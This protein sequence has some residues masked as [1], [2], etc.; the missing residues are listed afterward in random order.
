MKSAGAEV[1]H[2]DVTN[3]DK[4][5][6]EF[7]KAQKSMGSLNTAAYSLKYCSGSDFPKYVSCIKAFSLNIYTHDITPLYTCSCPARRGQFSGKIKGGAG[8]WVTRL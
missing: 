6:A 5:F 8:S 1:H 2:Y 7:L 3:D 4:L